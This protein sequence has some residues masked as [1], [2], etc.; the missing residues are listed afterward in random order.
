MFPRLIGRSLWAI[1]ICS[2]LTAGDSFSFDR[3]QSFLKTYCEACHQGKTAAGGFNVQAV[4][5][6]AS[7][8]SN[9][10]KWTRLN[11]RV[12]HGEMPPKNAPAPTLDSREQFTK[13]VEESLRGA[14]LLDRR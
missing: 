13:W 11:L 12:I 3:A 6:A 8:E 1:F 5:S 4:N 7:L 2:R 9:P 14:C 10:Q